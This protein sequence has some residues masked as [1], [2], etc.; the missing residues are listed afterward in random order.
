MEKNIYLNNINRDTFDSKKWELL[1]IDEAKKLSFDFIDFQ[2]EILKE[3][4]NII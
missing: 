3:E 4:L 1:S 2:T